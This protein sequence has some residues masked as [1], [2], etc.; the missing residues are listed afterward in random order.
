MLYLSSTMLYRD[1]RQHQRRNLCLIQLFA[2]TTPLITHSPSLNNIQSITFVLL[3][4]SF[5]AEGNIL[6]PEPRCYDN[7]N[8]KTST[9]YINP[10]SPLSS[11]FI[12]DSSSKDGGPKEL[13]EKIAQYP[14]HNRYIPG[15]PS[16]QEWLSN[17]YP[18]GTASDYQK[19]YKEVRNTR[20]RPSLRNTTDS[21]S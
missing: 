7:I 5:C 16:T 14:R 15:E 11:I 6:R 20:P 21:L 13:K 1:R 19:I 10:S 9:L 4:L 3:E 8:T 18:E 2:I 17:R 12:K